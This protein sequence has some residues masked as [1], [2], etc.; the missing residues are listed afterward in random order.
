MIRVSM[1]D[2]A[3]GL[4]TE[5]PMPFSAMQGLTRAWDKTHLQSSGSP[6]MEH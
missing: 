5:F 1:L 4:A 3:A 6:F 2:I